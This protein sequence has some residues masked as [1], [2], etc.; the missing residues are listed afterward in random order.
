MI[1]EAMRRAGWRECPSDDVADDWEARDGRWQQT[2]DPAQKADEELVPVVIRKG[3]PLC[4]IALTRPVSPLTWDYDARGW[5]ESLTPTE[6]G[7]Y[8]WRWDA[9][10]PWTAVDVYRSRNDGLQVMHSLSLDRGIFLDEMGGEWG[11]PCLG[12]P[13]GI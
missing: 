2:F 9:Q 4:P 3:E 12:M 1:T 7:W 8:W 5:G 13:E 6:P 11:G 10:H